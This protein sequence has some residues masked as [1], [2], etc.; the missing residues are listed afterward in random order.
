MRRS[1]S[2]NNAVI[3]QAL[4]KTKPLTLSSSSRDNSHGAEKG[5]QKIKLQGSSQ[6][7]HPQK[8]V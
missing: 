8:A 2:V 6:S 3:K 5:H 7:V 1:E 4:A